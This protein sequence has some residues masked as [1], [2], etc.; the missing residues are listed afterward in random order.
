MNKTRFKSLLTLLLLFTCQSLF[1]QDST[2]IKLHRADVSEYDAKYAKAQRLLGDVM[3]EH[4]GAVMYCDSAWLY[5]EDN[6][7]KAFGK[8]RVIQGDS[9]YLDAERLIYY[10]DSSL[11]ELFED[12]RLRDNEMT[13]TTDYLKYNTDTKVGTYFNG[14]KI[15]SSKNNNVLTSEQG[16][17]F[18]TNKSLHFKDSVLLV[19]PEYT[20]DTDTL[21]YYMNSEQAFFFGPTTINSDEDLI[22]CE[23][24]WYD[25]M[26]DLAQ[27][28]KDAY[29]WSDGQQLLGDSLYY[30]RNLAFGEAFGN[31][32][33][34]DTVNEFSIYGDYGK[35]LEK[36]NKS[37][38]TGM[39]LFQQFTEGDTLH[40]H[41]DTLY[42]VP[43]TLQKKNIL[44]YPRV[45]F[46]K[47]D[48]QGACDSLSFSERDSLLEM[49]RDPVIWSDENQIT[50]RK[51][52]IKSFD[53][54]IGKLF[55]KGNAFMISEVDTAHYN[56][57][58][59]KNLIGYFKDN[60]LHKV[61]IIGNGESIYFA[62]DDKDG[63]FIGVNKSTCT[64]ITVYIE[65]RAVTSVNFKIQPA[66][67]FYPLDQISKEKLKLK[68][69]KWEM[70][71]RP[72]TPN[73]IFKD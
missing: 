70:D 48:M 10:G 13:L 47:N 67:S 72:L 21:Q 65:D 52:E 37:F 61:D 24:G 8:V 68:K 39:A 1:S 18:A 30:D 60:E 14:G 17:Y 2:K 11:A 55:C 27:F 62:T 43:D 31:V 69:F 64:D 32:S 22:Y 54:Q 34:I 6:L 49:F 57:L 71:R 28:N 58:K 38:V 16:S 50:G 3:F 36:T 33:V 26:N 25:T 73:D 45:K 23:N 40:M 19:N 20:M 44:A 59:G 63:S 66:S 46:Y 29:L 56:Q 4:K 53:G 42:S 7:M 51:I 15:V 5:E 35:H 9:I 41:A 12:I